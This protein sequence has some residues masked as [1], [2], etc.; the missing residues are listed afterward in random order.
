MQLMYRSEITTFSNFH[1]TP[2]QTCSNGDIRR[3]LIEADR[4]DCMVALPGQFLYSKQIPVCLWFLAKNK[5]AAARRGFRYR[6]KQTLCIAARKL[7]RISRDLAHVGTG[8]T[9]VAFQVW[10]GENDGAKCECNFPHYIY[11]KAA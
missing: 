7:N 10:L 3:A 6:R 4:V 2:D 11:L 1:Y 9:D 8:K 5:A